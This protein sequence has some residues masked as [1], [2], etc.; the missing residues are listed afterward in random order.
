M[1]IIK[2]KLIKGTN[3]ALAG[4]MSLLGFNCS[5]CGS[6][7]PATEYGSP[8]A[9]YKVMGVIKNEK[10]EALNGIRIMVPEILINDA[11]GNE[12]L[13]LVNDTVYTDE[14][15]Q[16]SYKQTQY[17]PLDNVQM[18]LE[19]EDPTDTFEATS[20]SVQFNRSELSGGKGWFYGTSSKIKDFI[21][22]Q[23][24]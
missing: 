24:K 22:K 4:L 2:R 17:F 13:M 8:H 20:D 11:N 5:G 6:V 15:G 18:K 7:G 3:W 9:E 14:Q 12:N 16:F 1:K 21:L 10:G 19:V 23:K